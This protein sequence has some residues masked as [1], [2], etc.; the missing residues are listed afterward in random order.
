MSGKRV[1]VTGAN[2]GIGLE[3]SK[4]CAMRCVCAHHHHHHHHQHNTNKILS[5]QVPW[6]WSLM[7]L[8]WKAT[9]YLVC[10]SKERGEQ[11]QA[12]IKAATNNPNVH[13]K[14][15]TT[16]TN[17]NTNNEAMRQLAADFSA[18]GEPLH[19]L[20]QNAGVM[21]EV[22]FATNVLGPFVLTELLLPVL[23]RSAPSRVIFVASGGMLTETLE[24][25]DL[26]M[27]TA[28]SF[29]GQKQYAINKRQQV[30]L[31]ERWAELQSGHKDGGGVGFYSVHP[32]WA[33]TAAVRTFMPGFY[34]RLKSKLR[35]AE[36]G[37]DG[38]VWLACLADS[39]KLQ[40]GGFYLDRQPQ[41]KHLTLGG[42]HYGRKEVDRLWGRLREMG[43]LG[44]E[45]KGRE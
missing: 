27:A 9:V 15:S 6:C 41:S 23:E 42:T 17:D 13:L 33:D 39:A 19:V 10:R 24:T 7:W 4:A 5:L 31:V 30:A 2:S 12:E 37:A 45:S 22:N 16:P 25:E 18:S 26:Q 21:F 8:T 32:G 20:V 43:G 28:R 44:E 29:D 36:E 38:V 3:A 14:A 1:M 35:T 34:E 40:P 11:A